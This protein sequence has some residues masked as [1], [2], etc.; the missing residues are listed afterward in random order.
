MGLFSGNRDHEAAHY[1][2]NVRDQSNPGGRQ[3][4]ADTKVQP[5]T[6]AVKALGGRRDYSGKH[7]AS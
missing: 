3:H 1:N 2:G 7:R 5:N 6:D 4:A